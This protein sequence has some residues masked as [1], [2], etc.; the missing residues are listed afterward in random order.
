M[1][2]L[3][4]EHASIETY[5]KDVQ[6]LKI[7]STKHPEKLQ[8]LLD[9]ILQQKKNYE[10]GAGM[11]ELFKGEHAFH[12][13]NYEQALVHYMQ[14]KEIPNFEFFC[15]RATAYVSFVRGN[16]SKAK[17]FVQKAMEY[18][19][20]DYDTLKLYEEI[21]EQ[22]QDHDTAKTIGEMVRKMEEKA[23]IIDD[24]ISR[25]S[26]EKADEFLASNLNVDTNSER[27]LD[28]CIR[29]FEENQVQ[30]LQRYLN[31][32][33]DKQGKK[34]NM[35]YVLNAANRTQPLQATLATKLSM[36][37]QNEKASSGFFIRWHG[38]GV[39]INPGPEFLKN[40]HEQGL[41][42][43]D[44]NF[45]I[46]TLDRPEDVSDIKRIYDLNYRLNLINPEMHVIHYYLNHKSYQQ[47]APILT[48][49]FKQER[50]TV[51]SLELFLD[52]PDVEH[53]PLTDGI[54]LHYFFPFTHA[55]L[56]S[57]RSH[58]LG[59]RLDLSE[60]SETL[61]L[62]YL[63][64]TSW[65]PIIA[66]LFGNCDILILGFGATSPNDYRKLSHNEDGLGY[67]GTYSLLEELK[68]KVLLCTEFDGNNGDIRLAVAKK[69]QKEFR[70]AQ[71]DSSSFPCIIPAENGFI[72]SLNAQKIVCSV[73]K[74]LVD[75]KEMIVV[76]D[77]NPFGQLRYL[78][79]T[80]KL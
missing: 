34:D 11:H 80:C 60:G 76:N 40:L 69:L 75:P 19:P 61:R 64:R 15:Y 52:S 62:G 13:G 42:V 79:P 66:S 21:L 8:V 49:H 24:K 78:S 5:L 14:A 59:I 29:T 43:T 27:E 38:R 6:E 58:S 48:P 71:K 9:F 77:A 7:I 20:D 2:Q 44:I 73:S 56:Q 30:L 65:T 23:G 72:F 28:A 50:N 3:Q 37:E 39:A 53:A 1:D 70:Q 57:V 36:A 74:M 4:S 22:Q 54:D 18:Q 25:V 35:L 45:V 12:N 10:D 47:L 46:V 68:P 63:S 32:S 67:F 26:E 16:K 41:H 33:R 17:N 55:P 31:E 51:H